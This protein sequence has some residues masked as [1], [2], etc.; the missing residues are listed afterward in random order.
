VTFTTDL[1]T[2]SAAEATVDS[3]GEAE[4]TIKS[5]TDGTA[6]IT[7]TSGELS[8]AVLVT[9]GSSLSLSASPSSVLAND[10]DLSTLTATLTDAKPGT[11][12]TFT[13]SLGTLSA[14]SATSDASG[15]A[16]VTLKSGTV[17][18]ATVTAT[19]GNNSDSDTV[20]FTATNTL[21]INSITSPTG[22]G[23]PSEV[24]VV[25]GTCGTTTITPE[26]FFDDEA[27]VDFS[28]IG[29]SQVNITD[30]TITYTARDGGPSITPPYTADVAL[31]I[32]PEGSGSMTVNLI[33]VGSTGQSGTKLWY[34]IQT[35]ASGAFFTFD[36]LYTFTGNDLAG[37]AVS[38][39]GSLEIKVGNY[40]N[41]G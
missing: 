5:D 41:C 27:V 4:V 22:G 9:F 1:G 20:T 7:A 35:G 15:I 29:N 25:R 39:S 6:R 38:V 3:A 28:S 31:T 26:P 14:S 33:K 13:A 12:V 21:F 11:E 32:P 23:T 17:G 30:Y 8:S 16:Q 37:N 10:S 19:D 24:D 34:A 18:T 40:N 36:A 2:L